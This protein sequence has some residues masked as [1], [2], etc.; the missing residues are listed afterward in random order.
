MRYVGLDVGSQFHKLAIVDESGKAVGKTLRIDEDAEGY[1]K[2]RAAL[3]PTSECRIV[4]EATGHYWRNLALTLIGWEYSVAVV[5]PSRTR[6]F[7]DGDLVRTKT[8]SMDALVLARFAREKQPEPLRLPSD[9]H[10]DIKEWGRQ[11]ARLVVDLGAVRNS[12]HRLLDLVFPEFPRVLPDPTS[13]R[14]LKL[15]RLYPTARRMGRKTPEDVARVQYDGRHVIGD[16]LATQLIELARKSIAQHEGAAHELNV[17][18]LVAQAELLRQ[19][20]AE[21]DQLLSDA[22]D[23]DELGGLLQSVPGI[24]EATAATLI[25]E[26]GD[27]SQFASADKLVAY[28]GVNPGLRH[29]GK[30]T[31]KHAPMCKVGPKAVRQA[32]YLAALTA[33]RFNPVIRAFYKR[34]VE[35]GKPKKLAL[36]ACMRKLLLIIYS[37]AKRRKPFEP[38]IATS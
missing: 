38:L 30:H 36:G 18:Q 3:P 33:I 5:N 1:E 11:R 31:P 25:G 26:L 21:I 12:L 13:L 35:A 37:V 16:D 20:I 27:F 10:A 4:M 8:D 32:L 2:L 23:D 28:V 7:A 34:L 17:R 9:L 14:A 15:L 29:S 6:R 24:G 22:L 19:Q